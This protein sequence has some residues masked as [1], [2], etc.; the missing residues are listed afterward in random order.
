MIAAFFQKLVP[1]RL[2]PAALGRVPVD[3]FRPNRPYDRP[4]ICG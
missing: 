4:G 3:S 1:N 2:G